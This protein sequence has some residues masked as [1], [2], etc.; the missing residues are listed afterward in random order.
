MTVSGTI[1]SGQ[2]ALWITILDLPA[3]SWA[4]ERPSRGAAPPTGVC[5]AAFSATVPFTAPASNQAGRI[6]VWL[7]SPSERGNRAPRIG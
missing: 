1:A 6:Q 3:R 5:G 4:K 7:E 2:G